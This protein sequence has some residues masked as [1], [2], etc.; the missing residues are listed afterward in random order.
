MSGE[1]QSVVFAENQVFLRVNNREVSLDN[2]MA[3]HQPEKVEKI[4]DNI[5]LAK[6]D[7]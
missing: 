2:V 7:E 5:N 1:V 6:A 4:L 3:I